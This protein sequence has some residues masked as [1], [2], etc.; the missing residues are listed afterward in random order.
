MWSGNG[1]DGEQARARDLLPLGVAWPRA[2][3]SS[4]ACDRA[5]VLSARS[6]ARYQRSVLGMPTYLGAGGRT[7]CWIER[8][9]PPVGV[10]LVEDGAIGVED[11]EKRL[12]RAI[13]LGRD[14][15]RPGGR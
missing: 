3:S 6:S 15:A 9:G 14:P 2:G 10:E 12:Q 1:H 4:G 7:A 8:G 13:D 11:V 5:T